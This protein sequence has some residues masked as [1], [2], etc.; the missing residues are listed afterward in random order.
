MLVGD[1]AVV[2]KADVYRRQQGTHVLPTL[3]SEPLRL[4]T[5]VLAAKA[6][7][8]VR[9]LYYLVHL[10]MLTGSNGQR[11]AGQNGLA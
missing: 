10:L 8:S 7:L 4:N 11:T 1:F 6:T 9:D 5:H 2:S 3:P